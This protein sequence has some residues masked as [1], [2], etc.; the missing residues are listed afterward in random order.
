[1]SYEVILEPQAK[2]DFKK[3]PAHIKPLIARAIAN[4]ATTPRPPGCKKLQAR[5]EWRIRVGDY[6]VAYHVSDK[7]LKVRVT[8]VGKREHFYH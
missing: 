3:L 5:D 2:R 7:E 8:E 1:V 6:R 4:L